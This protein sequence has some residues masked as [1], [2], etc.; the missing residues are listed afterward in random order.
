MKR[1]LEKIIFAICVLIAIPL[2]ILGCYMVILICGFM[3]D[4]GTAY[5][6]LI[7]TMAFGGCAIIM[8][9]VY[10]IFYYWF[11]AMSE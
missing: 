8:G 2:T 10:C 11:K 9:I 7:V 3:T 5:E 1:V 4:S 6:W